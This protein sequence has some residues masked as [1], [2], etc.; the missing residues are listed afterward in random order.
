MAFVV[1]LGS[2]FLKQ[3]APAGS[4]TSVCRRSLV[5]LMNESEGSK[6]YK[7]LVLGGGNAAGYVARA[8]VEKGVDKSEAAIVS[9]EEVA[10]Y[11]RPA[12]SK[13]FLFADPPARLPGFHTCVGGG[14]DR[15]APEWYEENGIDL[16]LNEEIV[17]ADLNGK[18]I[19]SKSGAEF[20]FEKLIV[21]TGCAPI[22]L[23]KLEG[24]DLKGIHYLRE[25]ADALELYDSLHA[26]KGEEVLIVGGGYIGMEVA[27]AAAIVGCKPK[28]IFPE[29]HMM[30]RLF[31]PAMAKKYEAFYKEK[32]VEILKDGYLCEGF[33]GDGEGNLAGV[34]VAKD[35]KQEVIPGKLCVIGVGARPNAQLFSDQLETELGG[36]KVNGKFESSVKDVYAIGDVASFPLKKYNRM[37]R[38]EHVAH[39]RQSAAHA[40]DALFDSATADYDYLPYFYSR[41]FDLSWQFFGDSVGEPVLIGD[42][43]KMSAFWIENGQVNGVFVEGP[44]AED[45]ETMRAIASKR[46]TVDVDELSALSDPDE[47]L[48]LVASA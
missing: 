33:A 36:I 30:S 17:V 43:P 14:G 48:K 32:G 37:T 45:T 1:G 38:M 20:G 5:V 6:S 27:A 8:L 46:P 18:K 10:P 9:R 13:A 47:A 25:N 42:I 2:K 26:H 39:A 28:L 35:G 24:A 21:A 40:V 41:V 19:K 11:E 15:Q 3:N 22:K 23:S 31:F 4:K 44:T 16:N 12:L 29:E 34:K 7:Y